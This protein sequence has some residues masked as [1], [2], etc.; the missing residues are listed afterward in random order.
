[1]DADLAAH[2]DA[3]EALR[4]EQAR[5]LH[6]ELGSLLAAARMI[7]STLGAVPTPDAL[8]LLDGQLA[9]ALAIKQRVVEAL[10]PGLLDHFGPGIALAAYF[11]THCK[12][13]G[14]AFHA[15]VPFGLATPAPEDGILLYRIG[16]SVLALAKGE[17]ARGLRLSASVE[18]GVFRLRIDIEDLAV[19][20]GDAR[21]LDIP[22]CWIAQRGG[23]LD[24]RVDGACRIV[25]A[26]I[27]LR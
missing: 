3:V 7:V 11:E 5:Q 16:E 22:G 20:P 23:R 4:A 13:L 24:C 1:M 21:V 18:A 2:L 25:E 10:R 14:L 19:P 12:A 26:S 27:R 15:D 8:A 9:G 6:G 17:A